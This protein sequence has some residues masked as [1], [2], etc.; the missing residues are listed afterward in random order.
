LGAILAQ[1]ELADLAIEDLRRWQ[2]WDLTREVLTL[3]PK[4]GFHDVPLMQQ[5]IVRYAL[6]CEDAACR[7]FL[8]ERRR[9]EPEVVR[10]VEEQLR[11][12]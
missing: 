2:M 6:T 7:P 10:E 12:K 3:Y 8:E 5:A 4:K 9:A 1:G 11:Q